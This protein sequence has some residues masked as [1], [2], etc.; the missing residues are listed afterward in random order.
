MADHEETKRGSRLFDMLAPTVVLITP[1]VSVVNYHDYGFLKP[2]IA[3]CLTALIM[4]GLFCGLV[5][6]FTGRVPKS[7]VMA[8]ALALYVDVQFPILLSTFTRFVLAFAV[9]FTLN[10]LLST[11]LS[12]I[13]VAVFGTILV[14]T[15]LLHSDKAV[16]K[17]TNSSEVS[18]AS[19]NMP[20]IV[21]LILDEHIGVEGIPTEIQGGGELKETLKS[22]YVNNGFRL[23]GKAYSEFFYS[24][25]SLSHLVNMKESFQDGLVKSSA[26]G[27][28]FEVTKNDYFKL[29]AEKGYRLHVYQS[30]H[31]DFCPDQGVPSLKCYTYP[32]NT[33]RSLGNT[34]WPLL[35]KVKLIAG[36]YLNLSTFYKDTRK[37]YHRIYALLGHQNWHER[38]WDW[39]RYRMAPITTAAVFDE[40]KADLRKA[41]HGDFFFAHLLMPHSPYVFDAHCDLQTPSKWLTRKS[42]RTP[43]GAINNTKTREERYG[44]YFNQTKCLYRHLD[45]LLQILRRSENLEDAMLIFHG[46]HGS[47]IALFDPRGYNESHLSKS[48]YIDNY[49]TL[50]AVKSPGISQGYDLKLMPI[51]QL[52]AELAAA[53][54]K[55]LSERRELRMAPYV[56]TVARGKRVVGRIPMVDFGGGSD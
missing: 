26:M 2:E 20:V 50:F 46:D 38:A 4:T 27:F 19:S 15:L 33:I 24:T 56:H 45:E 48:D 13:V 34:T 44:G 9:F 47:R 5:F 16:P 37:V 7:F 55:S 18:L 1:F 11:H 32:A 23:F 22:F 40:L 21:H 31:M 6:S 39:D 35:E 25:N 41:S 42:L 36:F 43:S 10:W 14:T 49:S 52:F 54:F 51:Q 29:M 8:L 30:D 17:V 3:L 53:D 28:E 12:R